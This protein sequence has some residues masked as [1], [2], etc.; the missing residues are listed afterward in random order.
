MLGV[1]HVKLHLEDAVWM[2]MILGL[3]VYLEL[4]LKYSTLHSSLP[5]TE[6]TKQHLS[7]AKVKLSNE[8]YYAIS[9]RH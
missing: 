6:Q 4:L 3:T 1:L 2:K 7:L 5:W 9:S 8:V